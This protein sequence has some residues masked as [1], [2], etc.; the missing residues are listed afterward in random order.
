MLVVMVVLF[1]K[2]VGYQDNPMKTATVACALARKMRVSCHELNWSQAVT[3][4][5]KEKS[6][7]TPQLP[8]LRR[9]STESPTVRK[10]SIRR[11]IAPSLRQPKNH[12]QTASPR[13]HLNDRTPASRADVHGRGGVAELCL[14][15]GLGVSYNAE[16]HTE[17]PTRR[18]GHS[19]PGAGET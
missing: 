18:F 4:N 15:P 16:P 12:G 10:G 3:Q 6:S 5:A 8:A 9:L 19:P 7:T 14:W 2:E 13:H 11:T 17:T 1:G